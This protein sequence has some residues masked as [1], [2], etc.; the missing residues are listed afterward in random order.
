MFGAILNRDQVLE[1]IQEQGLIL[2]LPW[3]G[4]P[5]DPCDPST[6]DHTPSAPSNQ[7]GA[8]SA[9]GQTWNLTVCFYTTH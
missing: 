2:G 8:D 4:D 9:S 3:G 5:D 6:G 7:T 1:S